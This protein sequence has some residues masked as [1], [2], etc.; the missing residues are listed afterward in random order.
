MFDGG[1]PELVNLTRVVRKKILVNLAQNTL[2]KEFIKIN[3]STHPARLT[4]NLGLRIQYMLR[5][6]SF[7]SVRG[8]GSVVS[9]FTVSS[10][11]ADKCQNVNRY[12]RHSRFLTS[13]K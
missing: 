11:Q 9:L 4:Q 12:T 7:H 6:F 2:Q 1:N 13:H 3:D 5:I 8:L 10:C